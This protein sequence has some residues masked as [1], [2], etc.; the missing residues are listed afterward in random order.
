[1]SSLPLCPLPPLLC[2]MPLSATHVGTLFKGFR[3][4]CGGDFS[5][6][7]EE[8]GEREREINKL[9]Y[10]WQLMGCDTISNDRIDYDSK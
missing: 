8:K 10:L 1:M 4:T 9:K 2:G 7:R 3:C 6:E 5:T